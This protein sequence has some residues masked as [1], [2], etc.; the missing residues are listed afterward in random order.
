MLI[1]LFVNNKFIIPFAVVLLSTALF[2]S[3]SSKK[4]PAKKTTIDIPPGWYLSIYNTKV[5]VIKAQEKKPGYMI[6]IDR[7]NDLIDSD[8]YL[9]IA[10][11]IFPN[12]DRILK[13]KSVQSKQWYFER[14]WWY[15]KQGNVPVPY[16]LT[17]DT[18]N[19]YLNRYRDLKSHIK[20]TAQLVEFKEIDLKRIELL[21]TVKIVEEG[22]VQ[23]GE[24]S[25]PR[26]KVVFTMKWYEYCGQP[27]GWGFEKHREVVFAGKY[28]ILRISGDGPVKKWNSNQKTPYGPEQ[29]IK[30]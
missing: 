2:S 19:Y 3:C 22:S 8:Y 4:E 30:F 25:L 9:R 21:Y 11:S 10:E 14:P 18:I 12:Q 28:K 1:N 16:A 27:C 23:V 26:I 13:Q 5:N 17:A 7:Q 15:E 6:E 29:W 24:E 20:G